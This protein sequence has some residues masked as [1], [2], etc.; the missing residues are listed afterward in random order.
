MGVGACRGRHSQDTQHVQGPQLGNLQN[1]PRVLSSPLSTQT[2][3]R[4][5]LTSPSSSRLSVT[6]TG[7][8]CPQ[9]FP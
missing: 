1:L 8:N 2:G 9:E 3:P 7:H 4:G 5:P 6:G